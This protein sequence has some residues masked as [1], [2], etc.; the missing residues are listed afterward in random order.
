MLLGNSYLIIH[1]H[2]QKNHISFYTENVEAIRQEI[3]FLIPYL[4]ITE[5]E[6]GISPELFLLQK[7]K[8]LLYL[9]QIIP[10]ALWISVSSCFPYLLLTHQLIAV[11]LRFQPL[12]HRALTKITEELLLYFSVLIFFTLRTST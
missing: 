10:S 5:N 9:K 2:S 3:F 1:H 7:R 8:C 4:Q 11:W 12:S 6:S